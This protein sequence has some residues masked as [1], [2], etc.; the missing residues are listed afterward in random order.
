[1]MKDSRQPQHSFNPIVSRAAIPSGF[2]WIGWHFILSALMFCCLVFVGC[3]FREE[4]EL[5]PSESPKVRP[6]AKIQKTRGLGQAD[7][8]L[9][10]VAFGDSLTA[11][12]GVSPDQTYPARLEKRLQAAGYR[13]RVINAGVSGETT[14]GGVRRVEWILK[15]QPT[16]VI[17]ELGA[18]DALRGQPLEQSARN[19]TAIIARLQEAG[20]GIILAGMKIPLNYGEAYTQEFESMYGELADQFQ[21][22]LIPFFLEGVA[23]QRELNQGDG[24]H[25][26]GEGYAFVTENVWR[27]LEPMLQQRAHD[28]KTT[29]PL[30][31]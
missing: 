25:P 27:V 2:G 8:L 9:N 11:G 1:M 28:S 13:Y 4:G 3:D 14:A 24:I 20:V 12:L 18:N 30:L 31:D 26:T 15:N 21:I 22:P 5:S 19:L 7:P 10:I 23:A 6:E 29:T 16:Y 17:L